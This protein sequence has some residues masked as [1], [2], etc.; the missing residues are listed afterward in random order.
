ML[1]LSM[2]VIAGM[3]GMN[4]RILLRLGLVKNSFGN[5]LLF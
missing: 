4:I 1:S 5:G 2:V 3:I